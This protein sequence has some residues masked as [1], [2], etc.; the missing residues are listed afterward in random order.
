M[1]S[2]ELTGLFKRHHCAKIQCVE[3]TTSFAQVIL[4]YLLLIAM[5]VS[6]ESVWN[7]ENWRFWYERASKSPRHRWG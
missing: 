5:G 1:P 4:R 6:C 2:S 7:D 3:V